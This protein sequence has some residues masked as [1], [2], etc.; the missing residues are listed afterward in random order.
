MR[1]KAAAI[2]KAFLA[3]SL[4]LGRLPHL[5]N[6]VLTY[7]ACFTDVPSNVAQVDNVTPQTLYEHLSYLKRRYRFVPVDELIESNGAGGLA[8]VTFDDGY[9]TVLSAAL[10]VME[11]LEIPFT[12]FVN[13]TSLEGNIFWRHKLIHILQNGLQAEL[14]AAHQTPRNMYDRWK[15]P[16]TDMK[17]LEERI[18]SVLRR[19][20]TRL[21]NHLFDDVS[22]FIRHRLVWYGNHTHSHY[23]LA[24]L[25]KANQLQEICKTRDLLNSLRDVNKSKVF[26]L[27]FGET[28]HLTAETLDVIRGLGYLGVLMNRGGLNM[29]GIKASNGLPIVERFSPTEGDI[30]WMIKKQIIA[31]L[32]GSLRTN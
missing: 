28:H 6:P 32:A 20:D 15:S 27:P 10:P 9:K 8:A 1:Q 16:K 2:T 25:S 17:E 19:R 29:S 31:E 4:P 7:H 30:V 23:V 5:C 22:Y 24:A 11:S 13:T 12:I 3:R 26:S 14:G 18:D 21:V